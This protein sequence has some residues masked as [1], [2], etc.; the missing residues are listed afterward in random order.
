MAAG[1]SR[2]V[3]WVCAL[4]LPDLMSS[5]AAVCVALVA[6]REIILPAKVNGSGPGDVCLARVRCFALGVELCERARDVGAAG[7][8]AVVDLDLAAAVHLVDD[9]SGLIS[10]DHTES[11]IAVRLV[12]IA[13]LRV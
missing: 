9:P 3:V 13:A 12:K 5:P 11:V 6:A 1:C 4:L 10:R 8:F 7:V 2:P